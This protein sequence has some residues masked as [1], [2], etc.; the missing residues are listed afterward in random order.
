[1]FNKTNKQ[2]KLL[3]KEERFKKVASR[4]VQEILR[5]LRLLKNCANKN[6]YSYTNEQV[7]KIVSTIDA[8]WKKTKAE[9]NNSKPKKEEFSL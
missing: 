6:N 8:E 7:D 1:M 3:S 2:E 5:K 9:F 4:R